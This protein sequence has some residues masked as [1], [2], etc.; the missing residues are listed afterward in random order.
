M[1]GDTL[2]EEVQSVHKF[3][4]YLNYSKHILQTTSIVI[5]G[6]VQCKLL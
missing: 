4:K 6:K 3:N 5:G 2:N 1:D